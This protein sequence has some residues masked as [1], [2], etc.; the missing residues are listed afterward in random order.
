MRTPLAICVQPIG[1]CAGRD[2]FLRWAICDESH[3]RRRVDDENDV[4]VRRPGL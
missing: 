4:D 1:P 2:A 3:A